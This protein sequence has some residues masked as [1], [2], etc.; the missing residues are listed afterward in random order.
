MNYKNTPGTK[1]PKFQLL[2]SNFQ[3]YPTYQ[4]NLMFGGICQGANHFSNQIH[5]ANPALFDCFF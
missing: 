4:V 3:D 2:I 5:K 1:C